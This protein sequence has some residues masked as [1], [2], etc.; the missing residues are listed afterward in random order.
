M[1]RARTKIRMLSAMPMPAPGLRWV[2]N[3]VGG[4]GDV[5]GE[6]TGSRVVRIRR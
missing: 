2:R 3:V 4:R 1:S 5:E 6:L